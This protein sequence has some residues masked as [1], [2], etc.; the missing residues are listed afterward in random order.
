MEITG[1]AFSAERD[2]ILKIIIT[3]TDYD[4][5]IT[6]LEYELNTKKEELNDFF[7]SLKAD[8]EWSPA[9]EILEEL[10]VSVISSN[11]KVDEDDLYIIP[12]IEN[13][14]RRAIVDYVQQAKKHYQQEYI[15]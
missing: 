9:S 14:I 12:L 10:N 15:E 11:I 1:Q 5:I 4:E 2:I 3:G 6:N 8:V 7:L 13:T